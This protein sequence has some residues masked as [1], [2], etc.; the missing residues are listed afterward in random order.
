MGALM[1]ATEKVGGTMT[2]NEIGESLWMPQN[3]D[4]RLDEMRS[5]WKGFVVVRNANPNHAS[6]NHLLSANRM[7]ED[8][9]RKWQSSFLFNNLNRYRPHC[10][11]RHHHRRLLQA[12]PKSLVQVVSETVD[13]SAR[14]LTPSSDPL[15]M[16]G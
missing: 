4:R 5:F 13:Q 7:L 9:K 16:Q 10:H 15:P 14:N 11:R 6:F 12:I 3:P 8:T 2:V 1:L